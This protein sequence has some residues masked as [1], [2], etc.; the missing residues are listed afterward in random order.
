MIVVDT[1]VV[2]ELMRSAPSPD[3]VDWVESQPVGELYTTSITVAEISFG[4]E[5]LRAGRRRAVLAATAA[6]VFMAFAE[7]VLPFDVQ[8]AARY[9]RIAADRERAGAPITGFDGQIAAVCHARGATLATRNVKDFD[10][11]GIEV[12][13]PWSSNPPR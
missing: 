3:V 1:N 8:A 2:S 7:N 13:D 5:R 6:E 12:V 10:G 11:T 4:I 9:G